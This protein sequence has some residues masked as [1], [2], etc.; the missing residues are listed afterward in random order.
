MAAGEFSRGQQTR[1]DRA[2]REAETTCRWEFSVY[3]GP[4]QGPSREYAR[5]LHAALTTPPRSV[6][7]LVDPAARVFE[8]VTGAELRRALPDREVE[9]VG[10][11]MRADFADGELVD[12]IIRGVAALADRA[13]HRDDADT[14]P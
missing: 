10:D 5:T 9:Q 4:A 3:V 14:T 12:G 6:L 13:R 1:I 8:I 11:Q 2:I 7:V